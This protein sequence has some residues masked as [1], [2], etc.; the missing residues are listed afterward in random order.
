MSCQFAASVVAV[1]P[2]CCPCASRPKLVPCCA[3]DETYSALQ[4]VLTNMLGGSLQK[5]VDVEMRD[6][7]GVQTLKVCATHALQCV[8]MSC[9]F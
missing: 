9:V 6:G 2:V 8:M 7:T 1:P 5:S 4:K 3:G